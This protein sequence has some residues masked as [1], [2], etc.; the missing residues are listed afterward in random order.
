QRIRN[1]SA[2]PHQSGLIDAQLHR[3]D[4]GGLEPRAADITSQAIGVLPNNL[5]SISGARLVNAHPPRR[6]LP[7]AV[8]EGPNPTPTLLFGP[9]VDGSPGLCRPD[10]TPLAEAVRL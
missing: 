4:I 9:L 10:A 2:Y 1:A 5:H 6:A 3:D 8:P 7:V